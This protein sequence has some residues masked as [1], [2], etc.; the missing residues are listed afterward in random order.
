MASSYLESDVLNM[1]VHIPSQSDIKESENVTRETPFS[2]SSPKNGNCRRPR[3]RK[4]KLT[5]T[6][7]FNN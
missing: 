1:Q 6:F 7:F 2:L 3:E 5:L 4:L